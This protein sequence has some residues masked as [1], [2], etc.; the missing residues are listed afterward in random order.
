MAL[1]IAGACAAP[2]SIPSRLAAFPVD[3]LPKPLGATFDSAARA[4]GLVPLA[5]ARLGRSVEEIRFWA[6]GGVTAEQSFTRIIRSGNHVDGTL[7][8]YWR[9]INPNS[10]ASVTQGAMVRYFHAGTCRT[11]KDFGNIEACTLRFRQEPDWRAIWDSVIA[12]GVAT[13]PPQSSLSRPRVVVWDGTS[14]TIELRTADD[15]HRYFFSNPY[16]YHDSVDQKV[17]AIATLLRSAISLVPR[18][19]NE[20]RFRGLLDMTSSNSEFTACG[21]RVAWGI[22]MAGPSPARPSAT[23]S[24]AHALYYAD[25]WGQLAMPGIRWGL[26]YPEIVQ[27]FRVESVVPWGPKR[28]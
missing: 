19:S 14:L 18:S 15:Y 2:S 25:V 5:E 24:T 10:R 22:Q 26:P 9:E 17:V 12:L 28:C 7:G 21:S 4:Y 1:V 8:L 6:G 13:L 20:R 23:D 11:L 16:A 27:V 3:T